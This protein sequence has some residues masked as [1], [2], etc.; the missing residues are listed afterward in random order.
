MK[1]RMKI[2]NGQT[3]TLLPVTNKSGIK[4]QLNTWTKYGN[5]NFELF[6]DGV[7]MVSGSADAVNAAL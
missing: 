1:Y 4:Q 2:V 7:K 5:D 6:V 3:R